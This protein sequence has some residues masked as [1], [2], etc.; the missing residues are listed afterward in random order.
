VN[1]LVILRGPEN[2][3]A[4]QKGFNNTATARG[5]MQLLLAIA[6]GRVVSRAAS[7][8]MVQILLGQEYKDGVGPGV[9]EDVQVASK[10]GWTGDWFHDSGIVFPPNRKPYVLAMMTKGY[11]DEASAKESMKIISGIVY[12]DL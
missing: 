10:S 1:G 2:N 9:P 3:A 6:Q 5:L 11:P 8:E 7:E 12:R 4:F